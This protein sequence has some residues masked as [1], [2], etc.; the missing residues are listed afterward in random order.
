MVKSFYL[1]FYVGEQ[2]SPD[3]FLAMIYFKNG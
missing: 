2:L 1:T 3:V